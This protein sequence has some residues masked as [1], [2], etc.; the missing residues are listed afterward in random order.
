MKGTKD[1]RE[2]SKSYTQFANEIFLYAEILPAYEQLL[3][4]S[5]LNTSLVDEFVPRTYRAQFGVIEG[6]LQS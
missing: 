4:V 5:K 1:F 2:S 3:R 6:K